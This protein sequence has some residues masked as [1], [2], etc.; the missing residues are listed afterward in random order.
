MENY[1][2]ELSK[3]INE[4]LSLPIKEYLVLKAIQSHSY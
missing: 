4:K 2:C 1:E 3:A